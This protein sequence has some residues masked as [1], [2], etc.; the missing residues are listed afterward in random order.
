[1]NVCCLCESMRIFTKYYADFGDYFAKFMFFLIGMTQ[2]VI[3]F[4]SDDEGWRFVCIMNSTELK[5]I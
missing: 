1:L 2:I 4:R 5:L 3:N